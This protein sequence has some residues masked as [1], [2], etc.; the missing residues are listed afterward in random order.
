MNEERIEAHRTIADWDSAT[1]LYEWE[2]PTDYTKISADPR[3]DDCGE[4]YRVYH[5]P[6][7][8]DGIIME[9]LYEGRWYANAGERALI[10]H[11]LE[12]LGI[13]TQP[14]QNQQAESEQPE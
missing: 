4:K 14:K 9:S 10:R 7:A 12:R 2:K 13:D 11:L 6:G 1:L 5:D 8:N 3:H